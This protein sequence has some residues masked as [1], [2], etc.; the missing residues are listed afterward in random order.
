MC[1]VD[2]GVIPMS[3]YLTT[4]KVGDIVDIKANAAEQKGMSHKVRTSSLLPLSS[5]YADQ[6]SPLI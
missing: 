6:A 2:K 5:S 3:T 4:Y 1:A